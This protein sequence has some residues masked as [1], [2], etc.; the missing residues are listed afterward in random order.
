M[1]RKPPFWVSKTQE[2]YNEDYVVFMTDKLEDSLPLQSPPFVFIYIRRDLVGQSDTLNEIVEARENAEALYLRLPSNTNVDSLL[3][4]LEFFGESWE[5]MQ[6]AP[7]DNVIGIL[8]KIFRLDPVGHMGYGC[9]ES[10][11]VSRGHPSKHVSLEQA[12]AIYN[13]VKWLR[14]HPLPYEV[15]QDKFKL[16]GDD[17]SPTLL[18]FMKGYVKERC[19]FLQ[20][21]LQ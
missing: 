17:R 10:Y 14:L 3:R 8:W 11:R 16:Q 5:Y 4:I 1:E 2:H 6:E 21:L 9:W 15:N 18:D 13:C 20:E 7:P 19:D 12:V